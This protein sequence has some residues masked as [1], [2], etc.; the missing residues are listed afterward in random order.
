[1]DGP[2]GSAGVAELAG[3]VERVD[4]PHSVGGQ[5]GLVVN[6][7]LGEDGVVWA[8]PG[9]FGHEELVGLAVAS[10]SQEVG[11]AAVGAEREQQ[12]SGPFGQV[13]C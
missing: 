12:V 4:Y 1:V 9:Q 2:V 3:A 5:A 13:G 8:L 7:L 6:P 11:I 10:L